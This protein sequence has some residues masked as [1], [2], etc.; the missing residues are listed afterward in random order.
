MFTLFARGV[1]SCVRGVDPGAH[2]RAGPSIC[3]S[4]IVSSAEAG[5]AFVRL[6]GYVGRHDNPGTGSCTPDSGVLGGDWLRYRAGSDRRPLTR[7][8]VDV[9]VLDVDVG[10]SKPGSVNHDY[11]HGCSA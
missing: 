8:A 5:A 7:G 10:H 2:S 3:P 4:A 11:G 1:A 9:Y 6:H